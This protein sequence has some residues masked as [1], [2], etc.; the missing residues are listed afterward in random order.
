MPRTE[1]L[2]KLLTS[3]L[4][5]RITSLYQRRDNLR[6]QLLTVMGS[7]FLI[8]LIVIGT[9]VFY[10]TYRNEQ[11]FW[12][13]WQVNAAQHAGEAITSFVQRIEDTLGMVGALRREE[14]VNNPEAL[15]RLLRQNPALL[16]MIR[17][18]SAGQVIATAFQDEAVLVNQF[19]IPQSRW[20]IKSNAGELY[21]GE[22][23]ISAASE[24]YLIMSIPTPEG[25]VVA[26]RLHLDVL[27]QVV[28][29]LRFGETGQAYVINHAGQIVGHTN[30]EFALARTSLAGRPEMMA[31]LESPDRT[32]R[33][34]YRNFEGI[35]VLGVTGLIPGT[36]WLVITEVAR[37]EAFA[38]SRTALLL[39]SGG[40]ALFGL[41]V[42]LVTGRFLGTLILGPMEQLRAGT[43]RIGRGELTYQI[44]LPHQNEVGQVARA[45][46]EM[47]QRLRLREA[48]VADRTQALQ[49]SEERFRQ[50]VTSI[51]DHIYM[52]EIKG[53]GRPINRY[54]SPNIESLTG[55]PF[56]LFMAD[57]D[58]WPTTVIHPDD[59]AAAALQAEKLAGGASSEV[60]YRLVRADGSIIWVR[61]SGRVE[62]SAKEGNLIVYG[63]V[64]DITSR[65]QAELALA[66]ARD[67]ALAA[68]RFKSE[69]VANVSHELRTPL[70]SILGFT[71][72]LLDGFY[73]SISPLQAQTLEQIIESAHYLTARVNELL[74][75]ARLEAG[76]LALRPAPF[77]PAD[78][79]DDLR[80][81]MGVL[82]QNK[83][84][85]LKTEIAPN[86]PPSL[87][88][89]RDRLKQIL[90]NLVGNAIKFTEQGTVEIRLYRFDATRWGLAVS[91]TGPGIPAEART[92]IF[93]S[94]K[95]VDGSITRHHVGTG[96]GLSIVKQLVELMGGQI[97]LKSK[98]G[99]GSTFTVLLPL[100]TVEEVVL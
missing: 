25:G 8:T 77:K 5:N 66:K 42:M 85:T 88:G 89:D 13:A 50:V 63:L 19:T 93:E 17:L 40:L 65:K 38:A 46:N 16:E 31:L 44:E 3:R 94:F 30:P 96:L 56:D 58:F 73:D 37:S 64:G 2:M 12:Q 71:E 11:R 14:L 1:N 32:W 74:D 49:D 26:A 47:V 84:L 53:N 76:K 9:S 23:Q 83:G 22:V 43:E 90:I 100:E 52:T 78:L 20:F 57:W 28:D 60:E 68:S 81:K 62:K 39:L 80:A 33:G 75:Q 41:L 4:A 54:L 61:D 82:A 95:Q 15:P 48:Q 36:D 6:W 91:D 10:F 87:Q 99:A 7:M 34:R 51:S 67:E 45:F 35:D 70:N 18:D 86:L 27:W 92:D 24:P 72:M 98:V 29:S 97:S 79:V 59:R 55:Y 21:L 69:L